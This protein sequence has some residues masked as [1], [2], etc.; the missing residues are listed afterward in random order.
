MT[1]ASGT[2]VLPQKRGDWMTF[3]LCVVWELRVKGSQFHQLLCALLQYV[4]SPHWFAT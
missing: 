4:P 3:T 1:R 2:A